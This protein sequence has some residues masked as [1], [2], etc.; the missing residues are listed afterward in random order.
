MSTYWNRILYFFYYFLQADVPVVTWLRC[1]CR[2]RRS[3]SSHQS[4][5][6]NGHTTHTHTHTL[7]HADTSYTYALR[8][9]ARLECTATR[10]GRSAHERLQNGRGLSSLTQSNLRF[11]FNGALEHTYIIYY[12]A[13]I[14]KLFFLSIHCIVF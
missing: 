5:E 12:Y 1:R 13:G 6:N 10:D 4:T 14:Y 2:R 9:G 11:V 3:L 7:V 8:G